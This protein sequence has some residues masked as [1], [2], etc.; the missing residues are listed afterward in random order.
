MFLSFHLEY[1]LSIHFIILHFFYFSM[2]YLSPNFL[3]ISL[4]IYDILFHFPQGNGRSLSS[5]NAI[6]HSICVFLQPIS[7]SIYLLFVLVCLLFQVSIYALFL[8]LKKLYVPML[9]LF[10]AVSNYP[11]FSTVLFQ[12]AKSHRKMQRQ[13][14]HHGLEGF[15]SSLGNSKYLSIPNL[16]LNLHVY[17]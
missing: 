16:S 9:I 13:S 5:L 2:L 4:C 3:H 1:F 11:S 6:T 10:S 8:I 14:Q 12:T 17:S 7:N 15:G